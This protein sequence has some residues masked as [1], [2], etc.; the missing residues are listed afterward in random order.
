MRA[1]AKGSPTG[2]QPFRMLRVDIRRAYFYAAA[3][4]SIYIE[5]PVEYWEEGDENSVA[6]LDFSFYGTQDAAQNWSEEY[7]KALCDMGLVAG[8]VFPCNLVH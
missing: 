6:Q 5:I 7:T 4:R 3:K 1:E 2:R 8:I